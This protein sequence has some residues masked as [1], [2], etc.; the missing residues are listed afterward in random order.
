VT[1]QFDFTISDRQDRYSDF[2]NT[3]NGKISFRYQPFEMLTFRAAAST[4]FRAPTL[5]ELYR[6]PTFGATGEMNS[7][8]GCATG[9]YTAVFTQGNC[10]SQGLALFGGNTTLKPETS[11][12]FD[13]GFIVAPVI[14]LGITVDWYRITIKNEIQ[15][16][17]GT[18]IYG[19]PTQFASYYVLN[20]A[21]TLTQAPNLAIDCAPYTSPTCGYI[22]QNSQNTGG[23]ET[24]GLDISGKYIIRTAIGNFRASLEGTL[25]TKYLLQTY[26]GGPQLN[27]DGEFNQ[28]FQPRIRWSHELTVDWSKGPFGAGINNHFM[29]SYGDYALLAN[30]QVHTVGDYSLW[31]LYGSW[32]PVDAMTVVLGVSNVL[33]T[34]P[35]FSNQGGG[36]TTNWQSGY[37]PLFSDPTGRAF[38]ARLKYQFL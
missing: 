29:T 12:N 27:L 25:V 36:S 21:G 14:D 28:G 24:D 9:A 37:N 31:G 33:N 13:V 11:E 16:I 35:P 26:T 20:N 6:P 5:F 2:G 15:T 34:D 38:Y 8:P 19:N 3:N 32:K 18:A 4:G 17:P 7:Y 22:Y 23:I 30:G 10:T 1:R